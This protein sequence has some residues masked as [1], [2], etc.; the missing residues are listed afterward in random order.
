MGRIKNFREFKPV[1]EGGKA[2]K[3]SRPI[4]QDEAQKTLENIKEVL[5]P[6]LD[7]DSYKDGKDYII[8]GSLGKKKTMEETSGDIDLGFDGE[9]FSTK[10][11]IPFKQCSS[12]L[13]DFLKIELPKV[14]GF[15]PEMNNLIGL[16]ILSIGWP[17]TGDVKDGFVQLDLIPLKNME[18]AKFIYYS[19]DYR[20]D[21]SKWKSAHRNWLL[22][23]AL[24]AQR[25]ILARDE[26][27]E[28]LDYKTPVLLLPTGLYLH[29]KSYR[30][31]LKP[32]LKTAQKIEGSEEF[33]TDDPQE[34][35]NFALG[36]G[37]KEEDV[38]TFE[39]VLDIM[40]A[41]NFKYKEFL[42]EIKDKFI[43]LLN[44]TGL[45]IPPETERLG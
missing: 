13:Y 28:V 15:E 23:A 38:K 33:I 14:L 34:F 9:Y 20:I 32:R 41:P 3:D 42:P 4:R 45:P 27:G 17:V 31:K 19:P 12:R 6:L 8:I 30:G 21:E 25:E 35:I 7:L 26:A 22:T 16:N 43:E 37:Y 39:K 36:P 10:N 2:I 18:W 24:V 11:G 1:M 40:T 29:T 5:L 44:R